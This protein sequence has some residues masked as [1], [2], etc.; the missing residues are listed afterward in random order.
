MILE[1][2]IA[3]KGISRILHFTTTRGLLGSIASWS[4]KSRQQL[5]EDKYLEYVYQ[6]NA[7][8]RKDAQWLDYVNLSIERINGYF[9]NICAN[10]WHQDREWCVLA[11][12]PKILLH[13]GVVFTTTNNMYTDVQRDTGVKGLVLLYS[14]GIRSAGKLIIRS[15]KLLPSWPTCP[16]AEVLYP[17]E[18]SLNYLD[19]VFLSTDEQVDDLVAYLDVFNR[20]SVRYEVDLTVFKP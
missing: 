12:K 20:P 15:S 13:R 18:L 17:Q 11:F 1:E 9:F 4:L 10:K 7:N 5:P 3:A 8:I 19:R 2:Y 16:Q 14:S 6:P